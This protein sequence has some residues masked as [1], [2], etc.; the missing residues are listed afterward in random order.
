MPDAALDQLYSAPPEEFVLTRARLEREL[1]DAGEADAAAAIKRLRKPSLGVW[2][3]N[4]LAREEPDAVGELI[5]ATERVRGA[6]HEMLQGGNA[7]ALREEARNR[8]ALLDELVEQATHLLVGHAPNPRTYRD[9]VANLL[10]AASIDPEAINLLR[11]GHLAR[12]LTP[13]AGF[14]ALGEAPSAPNRPRTAAP[15]TAP[16]KQRREVERAQ[17]DVEAAQQRAGEAAQ[18]AEDADAEATSAGIAADTATARVAEV[19]RALEQSRFEQRSAANH[20]Q[21][22]HARATAAQRQAEETAERFRRAEERLRRLQRD[23][24]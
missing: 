23:D 20:A 10:E 21:E 19:E 2:A 18:A 8:Q 13:P 24:R 1:R 14:D 5:D 22:A 16:R 3:V 9:D 6:Q 17:R 11:A 7:D 15:S 4:R 12:T